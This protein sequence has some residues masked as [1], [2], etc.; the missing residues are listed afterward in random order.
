ML[1]EACGLPPAMGGEAPD[2]GGHSLPSGWMTSVRDRQRDFG[3]GAAADVALLNGRVGAK[4][5]KWF[6]HFLA[7]IFKSALSY[8]TQSTFKFPYRIALCE[9]Y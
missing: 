4:R 9:L 2:G 6:Q 8:G 7:E 3:R 5:A 1:P